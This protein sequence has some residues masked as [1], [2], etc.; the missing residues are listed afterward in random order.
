MPD[1]GVLKEVLSLALTNGGDFADVFVEQKATTGI[2]LEGG[3]IE[4]VHSGIDAGAGIR[5]LAG[6]TTAYAYTNDLSPQ[7]LKEAAH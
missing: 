2:V 3:K 5:V 6:D 1:K 4:R 7:G